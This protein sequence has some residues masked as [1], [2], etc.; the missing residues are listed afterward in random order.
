MDATNIFSQTNYI[1]RLWQLEGS[2]VVTHEPMFLRYKCDLT[3]QQP[4]KTNCFTTKLHL[5]VFQSDR[6]HYFCQY[7]TIHHKWVWLQ[8]PQVSSYHYRESGERTLF[9]DI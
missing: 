9:S 7:V 2:V 8:Q 6:K 3:E 4:G 1:H 5:L